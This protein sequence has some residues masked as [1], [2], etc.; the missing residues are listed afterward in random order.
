MHVYTEL[1]KIYT[2]MSFLFDCHEKSISSFNFRLNTFPCTSL[3]NSS[4]NA[5]P[6]ANSL[7]GATLPTIDNDTYHYLETIKYRARLIVSN[8]VLDRFP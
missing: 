3:G 2:E 5:T 6:P 1:A 4:T 7:Y 8:T